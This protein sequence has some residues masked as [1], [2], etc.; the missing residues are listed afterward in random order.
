[1]NTRRQKTALLLALLSLTLLLSGCRARTGGTGQPDAALT[2][3]AGTAQ[4]G[5]PEPDVPG[6]S[7]PS[8]AGDAVDPDS[9][10]EG[11]PGGPTREN[12]DA[13]RKEYDETA[14]A[15]IVGGTEHLLHEAGEGNG[16]PAAN[17]EAGES[18][19][20]VNALA[21]EA[22]L[23]TVAA[24]DSDRLG[25]SEDAD[26]ADSAMTYYTALLQSRS[27][28][29]FECQRATV[30]WETAQDHVT[31]YKTSPEH[32][33]ILGA[34]AY[35]V[36]A[37]LLPENLRVDDGWVARKNPG[38]IVKIVDGSV[39]GRGVHNPAAAG[40]AARRLVGRE[41]W[42]GIDAVRNRRV[43]L[44]SEE[45]LEAPHLRTAAMLL[46]ART[47]APDAFA[48]ADPDEALSAL[49]EEETGTLPTG[50]YYY[51]LTEDGT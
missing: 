10:E 13:S 9:P 21:E 36:S 3:G 16:A 27:A 48:D 39:L 6:D 22:A 41:G 33:L 26:A 14:P 8:A 4:E 18:E 45:I 47:A 42:A 40:E 28:A 1:M 35:D 44:L 23:R 2:S 38:V 43:L 12:P 25:V 17:E 7:G 15:E 31:V 51:S 5:I 37:R 19:N 20:Q 34:G 49:C 32:D 11:E 46:I 50:I 30:Y 29:L 24:P